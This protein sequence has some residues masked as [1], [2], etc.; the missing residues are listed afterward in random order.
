M[1]SRA[2]SPEGQGLP[3]SGHQSTG[4]DYLLEPEPPIQFSG[5]VS[6]AAPATQAD[7]PSRDQG[8]DEPDE[9]VLRA[10]HSLTPGSLEWKE[11]C[12]QISVKSLLAWTARHSSFDVSRLVEQSIP[13]MRFSTNARF[14]IKSQTFGDWTRRL[15]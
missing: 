4:L 5:Q 12:A 15:N 8:F 9:E 13:R 11:L 3:L 14:N 10:L 6:Q 2:S 1:S 7:M